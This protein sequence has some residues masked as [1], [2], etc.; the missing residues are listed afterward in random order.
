[1]ASDPKIAFSQSEHVLEYYRQL[2]DE[3]VETL[4]NIKR[5]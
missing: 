2:V 5:A 1:M 3:R 4:N